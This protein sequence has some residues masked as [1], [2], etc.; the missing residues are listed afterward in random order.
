VSKCGCN[1]VDDGRVAIDDQNARLRYAL[2]CHGLP[3]RS[4]RVWTAWPT[5]ERTGR[6][7]ESLRCRRSGLT[8]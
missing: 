4:R 7:T 5:D 3:F 8:V 6:W 2:T 1:R